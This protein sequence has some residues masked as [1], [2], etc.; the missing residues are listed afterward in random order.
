MV[1]PVAHELDCKLCN[2]GNSTVGKFTT[3]YAR[4]R[5]VCE[6]CGVFCEDARGLQDDPLTNVLTS[7]KVGIMGFTLLLQ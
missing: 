1:S 4:G 7:S 6:G 2:H 3:M 5:N